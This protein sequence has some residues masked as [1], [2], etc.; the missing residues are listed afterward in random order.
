MKDFTGRIAVVTGGGSGMGRDLHKFRREAGFDAF[1]AL[2]PVASNG[3]AAISRALRLW[4]C[5][6][7]NVSTVLATSPAFIARKA[8]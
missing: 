4:P 1:P 3:E 8:S 2:E 6:Q 5:R 7:S